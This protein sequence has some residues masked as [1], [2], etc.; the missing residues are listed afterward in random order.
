MCFEIF[1]LGLIIC[2]V[3]FI[4]LGYMFARLVCVC[5]KQQEEKRSRLHGQIFLVG[6]VATI[7]VTLYLFAHQDEFTGLD[8]ACYRQ[9]ATTFS[10]DA[11]GLHDVDTVY[12]SIPNELQKS[13]LFR[14]KG[15][16][17]R[18]LIFELNLDTCSTDPFFLP[19]LSLGATILPDIDLFVPICGALWFGILLAFGLYKGSVR[20]LFVSVGCFFATFWPMWFLRGFHT[21]AVGAILVATALLAALVPEM[22]ARKLD[23][24][25]IGLLLGCSVGY[26]FTM[27]V[28]AGIVAVYL[29]ITKGWTFRR[30]LL[31]ILGG[32]V[33]L[34]P[35]LYQLVYICTPYGNI[36]S[37]SS[38]SN[39]LANVKEIRFLFLALLC[40]IIVFVGFAAIILNQRLQ[41]KIHA[42]LDKNVAKINPILIVASALVWLV[43]AFFASPITE[44]F[45][46]I[47]SG[48]L[49]AL[50]LIILGAM[51]LALSKEEETVINS[52][53]VL[54]LSLMAA[55]FV[56]IKGVEIHVGLWSQR[57]FFP[58][59]VM[60]LP[61]LIVAL[62]SFKAKGKIKCLPIVLFMI[63]FVP[64][65]RWPVAYFG[66]Y[67]ASSNEAKGEPSLA[68]VLD[69]YIDK[70]NDEG[71]T[72]YIFDYFPHSV[73]FQ[74]DLNRCVLGVGEH[75]QWNYPEIVQWAFETTKTN[76]AKAF[77]IS[78]Y[79]TPMLEES[80]A[81]QPIRQIT[82]E[83]EKYTT[84]GV[85][86]VV[87][88]ESKAEI[89]STICL[90]G[91]PTRD[92]IQCVSFM[93]TLYPFGLRQPWGRTTKY[94]TWSRQGSGIVGPIPENG[95]KVLISISA[96]WAPP[97]S[98][99]SWQDQNLII[100]S[101]FGVKSM[102]QIS[103]TNEFGIYSCEIERTE[104]D[105]FGDSVTGVYRFYVEKPYD[106]SLYGTKGFDSDLGVIFKNVSIQCIK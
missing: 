89:K 103:A 5:N 63:S 23:V 81:M 84:K 42:F 46:T 49:Y 62:C 24:F 3:T 55:L 68:T 78:S 10:E 85:F 87:Y 25:L 86:P 47:Q 16:L 19:M 29:L 31:L 69:E 106:P 105:D 91:E 80:V 99:G 8:V 37:I 61:L 71:K 58:V 17:T 57:R 6:L 7:F 77:F 93:N 83:L 22:R 32:A 13:F 39:M 27:V 52:A 21:D 51:I 97:V 18:D 28:P 11:R 44:G 82:D 70:N 98:D 41:Q 104:E 94:G 30:L 43:Y 88:H 92:S 40:A 67:D 9:L 2:C 34:I 45:S 90:M 38:L 36:L 102:L 66:V 33:G 12:Q 35:M 74:H 72:I 54:M 65:I 20:G 79:G 14:P 1:F 76:Q 75:A 53:L 95:G 73:P 26:H 48:L 50:P 4:P 15:R 56:Y 96:M 101:P 64:I 100:E 60:F 59:V